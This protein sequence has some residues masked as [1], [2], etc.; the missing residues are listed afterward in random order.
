MIYSST[1]YFSISCGPVQVL[2]LEPTLCGL[3]K[4]VNMHLLFV[5]HVGTV[6]VRVLVCNQAKMMPICEPHLFSKLS[7]Q[8]HFHAKVSKNHGIDV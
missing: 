8:C 1:Y 6:F 2:E 4:E 3:A 7:P 5:V